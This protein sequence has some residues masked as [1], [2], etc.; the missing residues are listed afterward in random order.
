MANFTPT[1]TVFYAAAFIAA[2]MAGYTLPLPR[3]VE[4]KVRRI[5]R[6]FKPKGD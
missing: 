1:E 2:L 4:E 5:G 6:I 3:L